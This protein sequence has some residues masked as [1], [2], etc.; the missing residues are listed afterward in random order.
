MEFN[1]EADQ[2]GA[3][4]REGVRTHT[5]NIGDRDATAMINGDRVTLMRLAL[6]IARV[7]GLKIQLDGHIDGNA[8]YSAMSDEL[9]ESRTE[10]QRLANELRRLRDNLG[11]GP[12]LDE[13]GEP[14]TDAVKPNVNSELVERIALRA[15][16]MGGITRSSRIPVVNIYFS[17]DSHRIGYN[18]WTVSVEVK[19]PRKPNRLACAAGRDLNEALRRLAKEVGLS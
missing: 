7:T 1:I 8:V 16:E 2:A 18:G 9:K 11:T 4:L 3:R 19:A 15:K 14:L 5:L 17:A 10:C 6:N 13:H 12:Q